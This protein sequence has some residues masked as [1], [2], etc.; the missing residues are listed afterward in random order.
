MDKKPVK[1]RP[2]A[3]LKIGFRNLRHRLGVV[4]ETVI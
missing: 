2:M 3:H 1:T 4:Q